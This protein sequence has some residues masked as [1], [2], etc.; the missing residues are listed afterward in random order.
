MLW[1]KHV[2]FI[3]EEEKNIMFLSKISI[4]SC[5]IVFFVVIVYVLSLQKKFLRRHSKDCLKLVVNK[6][7]RC[8][9][10][11]NIINS[12]IFGEKNHH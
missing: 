1:K 8:L 6:R 12:K 3:G 7:L 2:Y 4:D 11:V 10:K 5:M 9:R